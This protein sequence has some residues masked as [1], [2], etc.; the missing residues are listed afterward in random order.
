MQTRLKDAAQCLLV[1]IETTS[2]SKKELI[3]LIDGEHES[4]QSWFAQR[5][6]GCG[7]KYEKE[8]EYLIK[9]R[10][11]LLAFYK[12]PA[13]HRKRRRAA[14]SS[15]VRSRRCAVARALQGMPL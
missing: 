15:K 13:E 4:A 1:I 9:D 8:V 7:V 14:T 6:A 3:G 10:D 5:R 12:F 11:A 2:E